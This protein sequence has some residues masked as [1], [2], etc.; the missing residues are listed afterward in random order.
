MVY[1]NNKN[2]GLY[3]M[4]SIVVDQTNARV[5]TRMVVYGAA[6]SGLPLYV[7]DETEF[8]AKFTLCADQ[9]HKSAAST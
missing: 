7:R 9:P 8:H 1:R 5:G 6:G 4:L 2:G 3:E